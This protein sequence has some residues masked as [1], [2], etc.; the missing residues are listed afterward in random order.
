MRCAAHSFQ[1]LLADVSDTPLV[2]SAVSTM[3][4]I[5]GQCA[6]MEVK[7]KLKSLQQAS[8]RPEGKLPLIP[9][10]T[11]CLLLGDQCV[12]VAAINYCI[13]RWSTTIYAMERLLE[14]R[15]F[16][17]IAI[18]NNPG[19]HFSP[20]HVHVLSHKSA[21]EADWHLLQ[22]AVERLRPPATATQ[23]VESDR[24]TLLTVL[25]YMHSP[26]YIAY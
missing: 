25:R 26:H 1:L 15:P 20:L 5:L 6:D 16:I 13:I 3:N 8:G 17:S 10:A 19:V 11:R 22:R 4:N 2:R 23:A 14:L 7:K 18:P 12:P 24:A 9:V 21:G